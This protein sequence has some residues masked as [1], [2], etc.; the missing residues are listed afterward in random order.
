LTIKIFISK[1][2][3][4]LSSLRFIDRCDGIYKMRRLTSVRPAFL[5]LPWYEG[6][7]R[8]FRTESMTKYTITFGVARWEATQRVMV[9]KLTR[10]TH[11]IAIQLHLVTECCTIRS[12]RSRRPVR[13]LLD[14]PSH[15]TK[16]KGIQHFYEVKYL[17]SLLTLWTT[18]FVAVCSTAPLMSVSFV[19]A[20][21]WWWWWWW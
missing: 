2:E 11:K 9:A 18:E 7:S 5:P 14:T 10:L 8:S 15:L 19:T 4:K 17:D 12:S 16:Y 3:P 13:K 6:V 1:T 20:V 21:W